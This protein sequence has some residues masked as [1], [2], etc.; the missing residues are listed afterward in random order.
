MQ[1]LPRFNTENKDFQMMQS[2]WAAILNPVLRN[3]SLDCI[4]LKG[5]SLGVGATV[6]NHKLGRTPQGWRVVDIDGAAT[7]YRSEALNNLTLTLTSDAA[8]TVSL[9]VF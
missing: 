3:P 8:V 9:E 1:Q 4:L 7:I 6:V 5:I 2:S